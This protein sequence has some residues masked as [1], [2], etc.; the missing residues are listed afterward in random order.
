MVHVSD[1]KFSSH[2]HSQLSSISNLAPSSHHCC[3][4]DSKFRF[5]KSDRFYFS[6]NCSLISR[7]F[8]TL[9]FSVVRCVY[10]FPNGFGNE[11]SIFHFH[12]HFHQTGTALSLAASWLHPHSTVAF[13]QGRL[14]EPIGSSQAPF[15]KT[16]TSAFRIG[17][18]L[19]VPTLLPQN[20]A[21]CKMREFGNRS[22]TPSG[23][24]AEINI[25]LKPFLG[26]WY[27]HTL[28]S[29]C[30]IHVNARKSSSAKCAN[31]QQPG[32]RLALCIAFSPRPHVIRFWFSRG[33]YVAPLM[34]S[35]FF[36]HRH[37]QL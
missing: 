12:F 2:L 28:D 15:L 8:F 4:H 23:S 20:C 10:I 17:G 19:L 26:I 27:Y 21:G 30:R 9:C 36:F 6:T 33:R 24:L 5:R 7:L 37:H 29:N 34:P 16:R 22:R 14:R 18:V 1:N 25:W 11:M 32:G 35:R 3:T 13:P 31:V